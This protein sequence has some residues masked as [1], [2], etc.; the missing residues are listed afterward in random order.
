MSQ[1]FNRSASVSAPGE[2]DSSLGEF[3][4]SNPWDI[5]EQG[6]N[7]SAFERQTRVPERWGQGI[8]R[9]QLPDGSRQRRRRPIRRR[10]GLSQRRPARSRRSPGRGRG[11]SPLRESVSQS[12]LPD[13]LAP[14]HGEQSPG[15]R[16]QADRD[17][18]G[19]WRSTR[20]LYPHNSF[21]S[22]MPCRVH[23]GL[24]DATKIDRLTIRWPS[25]AIQTLDDLAANRHVIIT[26]GQTGPA[27][28]ET[29]TPGR[30][31]QP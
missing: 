10:R 26:E 9:H 4:V 6:H 29:V 5:V 25:G 21:R 3:W 22:Q 15:Y 30:V 20:E 14:R 7:L 12:Q 18:R 24:G 16:R 27:A 23:F 11:G 19:T 2:V 13:R 8:R 17:L 28:V 31:V 1:P